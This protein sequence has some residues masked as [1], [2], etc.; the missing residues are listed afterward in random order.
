L[1]QHWVKKWSKKFTYLAKTNKKN[2][3]VESSQ[4]IFGNEMK[5]KRELELDK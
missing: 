5:R 1:R 4:A 2:G 3:H